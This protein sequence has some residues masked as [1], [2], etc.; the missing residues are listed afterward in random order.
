VPLTLNKKLGRNDPCWCGSGRKFK[1]CHLGRRAEAPLPFAA[2]QSLMRAAR[3]KKICFHPDAPRGCSEIGR[4]H[5]LQRA[6]VLAQIVDETQ[7][8]LKAN[9]LGAAVSRIA[10]VVEVGWRGASTFPGFCSAHDSALFGPIE[11]EE[12]T[13]SPQQTF[14]VGYRSLCHEVFAKDTSGIGLGK[15]RDA[16]DRGHSED[17]QLRIQE[18]LGTFRT[19]VLAGYEDNKWYKT[20]ADE[21]IK[22]G[23]YTKWGG[24]VFEVAGALSIA[25]AGSATPSFDLQENRIQDLG[26]LSRRV[27]PVMFGMVPGVDGS[28]RNLVVFSWPPACPGI[29]ALMVSMAVLPVEQLGD[30]LARFMLAHVENTFFSPRWWN[31]LTEPQKKE[32]L[33]LS[34]LIQP[35]DEKR[36][37]GEPK[38][39]DWEVVNVAL[40]PAGA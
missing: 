20:Q 9:V 13:G 10:Q 23:E 38:L 18:I 15:T 27:E 32:V 29:E 31:S 21:V 25:S 17:A 12:F 11:R 2:I 19:G 26:D 34:A 7:H 39:V 6:G 28:G 16:I 4:A 35:D 3:A 5:T 22:T 14:L 1:K 24:A 33:R 36:I 30:A 40:R 37:L 8:V